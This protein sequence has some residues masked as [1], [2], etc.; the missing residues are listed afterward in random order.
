MANVLRRPI[1]I[2]AEPV[3]RSIEGSALAPNNCGGIYLPLLWEPKDCFKSPIVIGYNDNHFVPLLSQ[4]DPLDIAYKAPS[5]E[6]AIPLVTN[7][8][9]S[10]MIHFVT[11]E[12]EA[13]SFKLLTMYLRNTELV[14]T[15]ADSVQTVPCA[16]FTFIDL[17]EAVN[18][19]GDLFPNFDNPMLRETHHRTENNLSHTERPSHLY[20]I[21]KP[22]MRTQSPQPNPLNLSTDP[23]ANMPRPIQQSSNG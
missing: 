21:S 11:H 2:V 14:R 9:G 5:G 4:Q 1:I 16:R 19:M 22:V 13:V 10:L 20:G 18:V 15:L 8:L 6:H 23:E 17:D 12:E 7:E 3:M